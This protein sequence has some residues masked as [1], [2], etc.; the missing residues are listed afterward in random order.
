MLACVLPLRLPETSSVWDL[1]TSRI[2]VLIKH[3]STSII[4]CM[5][6]I[7]KYSPHIYH[8]TY[9]LITAKHFLDFPGP[10][11]FIHAR[12]ASQKTCKTCPWH[13]LICVHL[14]QVPWRLRWLCRSQWPP[15]RTWFKQTTH[16]GMALISFWFWWLSNLI[17]SSWNVS[18]A[19][20]KIEMQCDNVGLT[21]M[22]K[23]SLKSRES[24]GHFLFRLFTL[25]T[26]NK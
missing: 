5:Y 8:N 26:S 17:D 19:S 18:W 23:P 6:C 14:R 2:T 16:I 22:P 11:G 13:F 7:Y 15:R 21:S 1:W 4:L 12:Y 24:F 9:W 25:N 20:W 3:A 10:D